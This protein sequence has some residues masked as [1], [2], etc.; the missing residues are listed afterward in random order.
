[1]TRRRRIKLICRWAGIVILVL[2]GMTLVRRLVI[3]WECTIWGGSGSMTADVVE[4]DSG[5]IVYH[6]NWDINVFDGWSCGVTVDDPYQQ[7]SSASA[8]LLGQY[9]AQPGP[10]TPYKRML[11][12]PAIAPLGLS[13]VLI[14]FSFWLRYPKGH[15]RKCGYDLSGITDQ[16][17][18]CGRAVKEAQP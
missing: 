15:C 17:P 5:L 7:T 9:D 1:M 6:D 12:I 16:C 3:A 14:G 10:A 4:F 2:W 8:Y 13:A 18:E 11:I